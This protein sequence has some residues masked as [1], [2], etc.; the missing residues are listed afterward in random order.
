MKYVLQNGILRYYESGVHKSEL[1]KA[2]VRKNK[3]T[4][5]NEMAMNPLSVATQINQ[6]IDEGTDAANLPK[7]SAVY[8]ARTALRRA[9]G[10]RSVP[11]TPGEWFEVASSRTPNPG[12]PEWRLTVDPAH[13]SRDSR[14]LVLRSK[15][16]TSLAEQMAHTHGPQCKFR[17]CCD[18]AHD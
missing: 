16:L 17:V 2:Q 5:A 18:A 3:Q 4:T 7:E 15:Y 9:A 14:I 13:S 10:A 12:D 8:N 1:S 11:S 6:R